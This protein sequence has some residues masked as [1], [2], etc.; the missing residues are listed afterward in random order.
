MHI[1]IEGVAGY[2]EILMCARC[3]KKSGMAFIRQII[4]K[5]IKNVGLM[6][7]LTDRIELGFMYRIKCY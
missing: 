4:H 7:D 1:D 3:Q 2:V 6:T 5:D